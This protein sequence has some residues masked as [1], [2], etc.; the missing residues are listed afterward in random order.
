MSEEFCGDVLVL[1]SVDGSEISIKNGLIMPD[2]G[3][4]TAVFLS[5][6]GGNEEDSGDV[7]NRNTWWGNFVD[8]G[9]N[10]KLVS[11]FQAFIKTFPLTTKNLLIAEKK[12]EEDLKWF[13]DEG[14]ADSVSAN[15]TVQENNYINLNIVIGKAG[16]LVEDGNY[17]LQ[18]ENMR[19]GVRE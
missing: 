17:S 1:D 18:W 3:F 6:F 4:R 14:I 13:I 16:E 15:I 12:A 10:E 5:L 2:M 7:K 8:A 19:D 9:K 11:L